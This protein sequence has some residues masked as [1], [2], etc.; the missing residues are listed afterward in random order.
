MGHNSVILVL[1]DCLSDI[2]KDPEFGKKI[3]RACAKAFMRRDIRVDIQSGG[4]INAASVITT[5]H[6]DLISIL[7]VGGNY[8]S[9]IHRIYNSKCAHHKEEDQINLLKK[10]AEHFGYRLVKKTTK[11]KE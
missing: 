3:S 7:A 2:E 4:C 6:A 8:G 10:V 5:H 11:K 9:V 1:N